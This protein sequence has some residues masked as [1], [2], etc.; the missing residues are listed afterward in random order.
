MQERPPIS[1]EDDLDD[2]DYQVRE[3]YAQ[4]GLTVYKAQVL[5]KGIVT[6]TTFAEA[7]ITGE[8]DPDRFAELYDTLWEA[9]YAL[10]LGPLLKKFRRLVE[11]DPKLAAELNAALKARNRLAHT[12]FWEHAEDFMSVPGREDMLSELLLLLDRFDDLDKR[13]D[14]LTHERVRSKAGWSL[15]QFSREVDAHVSAARER[16]AEREART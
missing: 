4:F 14:A 8:R 5:E 2:E 10:T 15:D 16:I 9:N 6:T 1:R 13:I 12:F 3:V 11:N 7:V